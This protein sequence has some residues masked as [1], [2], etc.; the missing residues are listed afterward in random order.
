[1]TDTLLSA[2]RESI[3]EGDLV[4]VAYPLSDKTNNPAKKLDGMEFTVRRKH[5][6]N[7]SKNAK[8]TRHYFE[9]NGAVSDLGIHYGFCEDEL[10]KL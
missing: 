6:V 5:L 2:A 4:M 8:V 3:N 9:L 10:I 1:M 7:E